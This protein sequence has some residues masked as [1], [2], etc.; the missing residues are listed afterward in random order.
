MSDPLRIVTY[1]VRYFGPSLRGLAST[2]GPKRRIAAALLTL[3]PLPDI[4]CLQEVETISLR[5]RAAFKNSHDEETQL[6][7]FMHR[8]E[9]AFAGMEVPCPYQA[10]YFRAHQYRFRST[11]IFTTGL[12]IL[13]NVQR[14][15]VDEHNVEAPHHITVPLWEG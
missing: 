2:I 11:P 13:V 5:S 10:F 8:L 9:A 1:N 15:E 6:E 14:L 12:A 4:I 3:D 7:A